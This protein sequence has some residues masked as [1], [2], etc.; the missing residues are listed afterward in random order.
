MLI[1]ALVLSY[2]RKRRLFHTFLFTSVIIIYV[3]SIRP[4]AD[5]L[6][7]PLE[8]KYLVD[9]KDISRADAIV[10]LSGGEGM[11]IIKGISLFHKKTAPLIIMT[12]GSSS[13]FDQSLKSALLMKEVAMEL[14]VPDGRIIAETESRNSRENALNTKQI[15]D[16]MNV[17]RIMLV[18]SAFHMPRAYALFKKIGVDA[19]PVASDVIIKPTPYDPFSFVPNVGNLSLSSLAIKE[20]VGIVAYWIK[21]WI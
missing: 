4:T 16:K 5:L 2:L 11:R 9:E 1:T 10:V 7:Y 17:Q 21:G 8:H 12:G 14:G 20:Y 3:F 18:T 15:L 19:I 13:L 6:L